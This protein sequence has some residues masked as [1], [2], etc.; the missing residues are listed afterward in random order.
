MS[1]QN[2]SSSDSLWWVAL[3]GL[4]VLWFFTGKFDGCSSTELDK[5]EIGERTAVVETSPRTDVQN[6]TGV[7]RAV[8]STTTSAEVPSSACGCANP[9]IDDVSRPISWDDVKENYDYVDCAVSESPEVYQESLGL[10]E[11][12]HVFVYYNSKVDIYRCRLLYSWPGS[13]CSMISKSAGPYTITS[14]TISNE[15]YSSGKWK[16][17]SYWFERQVEAITYRR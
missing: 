16:T 15:T 8:G 17:Y 1:E 6:E 9:P 2:E 14:A 5:N 7:R 11:R 12:I 13:S 3:I 10:I 4:V